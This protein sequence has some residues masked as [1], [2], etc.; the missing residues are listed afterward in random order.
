[1]AA[2]ERVTVE[3]YLDSDPTLRDSRDLLLDNIYHEIVLREGRGETPV[4]D[5]Y[6]HRFPDL[7]EDLRIQFEV[8]VG[9]GRTGGK[10]RRKR[11]RLPA[12]PGYTVA[13]RIGRGGMGVVYKAR[14]KDLG[15][16]VAI[17]VIR[18][19]AAAD[20]D[21]LVRFRHEAE[22]VARVN[23]PKVVQ[24]HQ[25][26]ER[27]GCPFLILEYVAGGSLDRRLRGR[28]LAARPAAD[29]MAILARAVDHLHRHGIVHCDLKPANVLLAAGDTIGGVNL[30]PAAEP[31]TR[32]VSK[33]ADF[34]FAR[35]LDAES[36]GR[37]GRAAGTP[38][39]MAPE[40]V[41]GPTHGIGP[42]TD[43]YALGAILYE[44]LVG[45]PPFLGDNLLEL[46]HQV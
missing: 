23:H 21:E 33:V 3:H 39:Y 10:P 4:L 40:Q 44:L 46:F 43:V 34:G 8:H 11:E 27:K 38:Q 31:P 22:A 35:K 1:M 37:S 6:Q 20:P 41:S 13:K 26:G 25:V 24:I 18:D 32:F 36:A 28:P 17:K 5:E 16:E 42:A 15:R 30:A 12:V 29:L 45:R 2:G 14:Q 9:L 7:S 19:W